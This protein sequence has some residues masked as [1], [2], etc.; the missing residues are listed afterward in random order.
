VGGLAVSARVEPRFTRDIDLAVVVPDDRGAERLVRELQ[1][2]GYRVLAI[3][4]QEATGRLAT[5]RLAMP[6][7][8]D[9]GIV[10]DLLLAS[11][12]IEPEL[13]AAATALEVVAGLSVPV[14]TIGHL[15][16]LKLLAR[17]ERSR[18]QDDM[19]LVHLIGA[20][21]AGDV[22]EA[23]RAISLIEERGFHRGRQLSA[24]LARRLAERARG[25]G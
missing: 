13:A 14:A 18:P 9:Q 6:H 21:D 7:E 24:D 23:R 12:G 15:I 16:A 17:D 5:A 8:A 2:R 4:E 11:S 20:A 22:H 25:S 1:A 19:D 3:V 10:L